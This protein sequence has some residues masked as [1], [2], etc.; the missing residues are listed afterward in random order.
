MERPLHV[1]CLTRITL[2]HAIKGGMEVHVDTLARGLAR[3]GHRVTIVTTGRE[4]GPPEE[5]SGGVR[6]LYLP[7]TRPG[8]YSD[9][10]GRALPAALRRLHAEDPIDAIWGEAAGAFYYL[11]WHRNPLRLPVV[12]YLQGTY[13]GELGTVWTLARAAGAWRRF[14]AF[15]PWRTIQYFRWD[16]WYTRGAD[17]VIG[18]S[19]ENAALARWGY[20]LPARRLTAS[21]NGVDV[22]RFAPDT[23]GRTVRDKLGIA[24]DVP[25]LLHCSR[26]ELEKGAQVSV[27]ALARVRRRHPSARL[28]VAGDG[29][30]RESLPALA[31]SLGVAE[32]VDFLGH[33]DNE[34]L[35]AIY[36]AATVFLY[37]TLAVESFGIAV[38]EAMACGVPVVASRLGGVQTSIDD[39]VNGAL[40]PAGSVPALADAV[41]RL[42]ADPAARARIGA[43]ARAKAVAS[44]S[45]ARMVDDVLGV[46]RGVVGHHRS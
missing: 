14:F 34:A 9:D 42:L 20:L 12:T 28:L 24:P 7:G 45:E 31:A 33:V 10:W 6:T 30:Q 36:T 3:R 18:A 4:D 11:K 2:G 1:C 13:L 41:D 32:A 21:I 5:R 35:P 40:V 26:L 15:V 46:L 8:R 43:A 25:V 27:R 29:A 23:A 37:P 38:A 22:E 17:A 16:L 44:L 19:R 39:G